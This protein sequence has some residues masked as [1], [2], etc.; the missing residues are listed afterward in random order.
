MIA[1][2][3]ELRAAGAAL[4]LLGLL[5]QSAP[6]FAQAGPPVRL[7]P[8]PTAKPQVETAPLEQSEPAATP[9]EPSEAQQQPASPAIEVGQTKPVSTESVGLL[10]PAKA[11]LPVTVWQGASRGVVERLIAIL[12]NATV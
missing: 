5:V 6:A 10:D 1:S 9:S 2:R 12:P 3:A 8:P 4:A 11:G 7:T